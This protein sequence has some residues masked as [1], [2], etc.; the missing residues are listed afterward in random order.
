MNDYGHSDMAVL[1]YH[2]SDLY[3]VPESEARANYYYITGTPTAW[4]DGTDRVVGGGVPMR[5]YY[6]PIVT[7]H[8]QDDPY[9]TLDLSGS[10]IDDTGGTI[11]LHVEVT[12]TITLSSVRVRYAI[13]ESGVLYGESFLVR[14]MLADDNLTVSAVGET[15]DFVKTF[16]IDPGWYGNVTPENV[17]VVV[18]VQAHF[19]KEVLNAATLS[20]IDVEVTPETA[21]VPMGTD[22]NFNVDLT[23]IT[24]WA[25]PFDVWLDVILPNGSEFGGNPY[26]GP[27]SLNFGGN[28]SISQPVTLP[29]PDGIPAADYRLRVG[30]G[31]HAQPDHREYDYMTV[32]VTP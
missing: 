29:I 7:S 12:K 6:E 8:L 27:F 1:F 4:F 5:P 30:V 19:S 2:I 23:N 22:L 16:T 3:S 21:V 26:M 9:V 20:N 15:Q 13:V 18:F 17:G 31:D 10:S 24:P 14:D 25:Q 32:T 11:N 28:Q